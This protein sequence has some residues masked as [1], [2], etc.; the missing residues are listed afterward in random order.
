MDRLTT[1]PIHTYMYI[2]ITCGP[3]EKQMQIKLEKR[4][5]KNY[6]EGESKRNSRGLYESNLWWL[7]PFIVYCTCII[8]LYHFD[9]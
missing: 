8:P 7:D 9:E 2:K 4:E 3:E 6:R 1:F 5:R